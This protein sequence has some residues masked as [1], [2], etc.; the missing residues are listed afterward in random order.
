M[1]GMSIRLTLVA[2]S[3]VAVSFLASGCAKKQ[4]VAT[5]EPTAQ[6]PEPPPTPPPAPPKPEVD[7]NAW[8]SSVKDVFFDF[9]KYDLRADS[10]AVL[11]EDAR[12]LKDHPDAMMVLEGHCDERGTEDYNLALGQRRADAVRSYLMDLGVDGG[13]LQ[14]IS[15]GEE[16][17]FATGHDEEAWAQNRRVHFTFK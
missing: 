4:A 14:T 5:P 3:L 10:R 13:Q 15:Y 12:A 1:S 6:P 11:Q 17:P 2:T 8:K 16:K 7:P 9:D